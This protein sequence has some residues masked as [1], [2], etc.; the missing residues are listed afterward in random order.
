MDGLRIRRWRDPWDNSRSDSL[1]L[2]VAILCGGYGTRL[3]DLTKS[4]QKCLVDVNGKPFLKHV[5]ELLKQQGVKQVVM[6]VGH[7]GEQVQDRIGYGTPGGIDITYSWDGDSTIGTAAAL[8]KPALAG[9]L[10]ERFFVLYG[11]SYLPIDLEPIQAVYEYRQVLGLMVVC[12]PP[13]GY[14]PNV[15]FERGYIWDY[16]KRMQG[17]SMAHIDYGLGILSRRAL[18]AR[19]YNL[20]D[21]SDVYSNLA[22]EGQLAGY[23]SNERFHTIGTP[24]GLQHTSEYLSEHAILR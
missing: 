9:L 23:L 16:D 22:D 6:C 7:L 5:L 11:D 4:T 2:P 13:E 19:A 20:P 12:K 24:T 3:G 8:L 14:K 15:W 18:T 1:M 21:L 17:K 10:G